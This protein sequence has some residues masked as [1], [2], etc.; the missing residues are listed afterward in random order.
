MKNSLTRQLLLAVITLGIAVIATVGSTYAWFSMNTTVEATGIQ[1]TA[2]TPVNVVISKDGTNFTNSVEFDTKV[3]GLYPAS[4][5]KSLLAA[6]HDY[7]FWAVQEGQVI[8]SNGEGGKATEGSNG[9]KFQTTAFT[10]DA[11]VNGKQYFIAETIYLKTTAGKLSLTLKSIN[12]GD[13][14]DQDVIDSNGG[15]VSSSATTSSGTKNLKDAIYVALINKNG[16]FIYQADGTSGTVTG[17]LSVDSNGVWTK[18]S[19]TVLSVTGA[20]ETK[21]FNVGSDG[22]ELGT[23]A[24]EVTVLVW[25]EGEDPDCVNAIGGLGLNIGLTFGY[26]EGSFNPAA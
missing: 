11:P 22:Q 10:S 8:G 23:S 6:V 4:T 25:L 5:D 24:E 20:T 19:E 13:V 18:G 1:L 26:V 9:T 2:T 17:V 7:T 14:T 16:A 12:L 15:A 21:I 3:V